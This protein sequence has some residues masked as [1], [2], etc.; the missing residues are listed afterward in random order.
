MGHRAR[1]GL[2]R[3]GDLAGL[4]DRVG[5]HAAHGEVGAGGAAGADA[6]ELLGLGGS[7]GKCQGG[8]GQ[9]EAAGELHE[10]M[11]LER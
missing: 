5:D 11:L 9:N 3:G 2:G 1:T 6:E 4:A 8:G 7:A 10:A